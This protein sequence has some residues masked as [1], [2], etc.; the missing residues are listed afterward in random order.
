M[1]YRDTGFFRRLAAS[2]LGSVASLTPPLVVNVLY[3]L[4][5]SWEWFQHPAATFI[6]IG[7]VATL[8]MV[9][10]LVVGHVVARWFVRRRLPRATPHLATA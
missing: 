3:A 4:F 8:V 7:S 9:A 5:F 6:G 2:L 10:Q 1:F